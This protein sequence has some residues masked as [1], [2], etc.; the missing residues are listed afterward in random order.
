MANFADRKHAIDEIDSAIELLC[1]ANGSCTVTEVL[2]LARVTSSEQNK[3]LVLLRAQYYEYRIQ[4]VHGGH[5]ILDTIWD[6]K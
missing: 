4:S 3:M 6:E 1:M 5:R 2:R